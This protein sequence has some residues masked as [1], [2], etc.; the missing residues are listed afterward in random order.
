MP[1]PKSKACFVHPAARSAV[2]QVEAVDVSFGDP[3]N[4]VSGTIS[5]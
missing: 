2:K 1:S 4:E 3:Q 5:Y